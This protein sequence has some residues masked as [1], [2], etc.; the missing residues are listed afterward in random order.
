MTARYFP[1]GAT[2]ADNM[3]CGDTICISPVSFASSNTGPLTSPQK[4]LVAHGI[5][6]VLGYLLFMPIGILVGRYFRTVS[7]AWRTGHIIVQVAIAGPMIIAGVALGIAGSGEAHLRDLHKK[8]GVALFVLYFVQCALG[9]IITLFHPRGRARRPIQ[10]YFHVLLG[11]FIVGASFYQV[12]TGF[13]YEWLY[14]A[15]HGRIS[16]AAQIVWYVWVVLLPVLY[17]AGLSLLPKQFSQERAK[18]EKMLQ[19][20]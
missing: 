7:P 16:N 12:R 19:K 11:L 17:L 2:L 1:D 14:H 6:T 8:W 15:H 20:S 3:E 13:K 5:L 18:R 9:A 4:M 10:N